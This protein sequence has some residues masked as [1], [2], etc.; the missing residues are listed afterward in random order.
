[1]PGIMGI[2]SRALVEER[3]IDQ[4]IGCLAHEPFYGFGKYINKKIGLYCGW[5]CHNGSFSD[6]MPVWN[7]TKNV[8]LIFAGEDFRDP[9]EIDILKARGHQCDSENASYLVHLYEELGLKFI[10]KLNGWF[11]GL[12]IDL[13]VGKAFLFNDRYAMHRVFVHESN[14][15][16]YFSSEAKAL[17]A[18]LPQTRKFDPKGLGEFMTCGC[19]IGNQSLYKGISILP[20]A[21]LWEFE[22]GKVKNRG[23]YFGLE[24]WTGQQKLSEDQFFYEFLETFPKV[25]KQYSSN[26]SSSVGLSLTGG[27]DSRM[28]IACLDKIPGKY[29]CYTFGSMYRDTYDVQTA[30]EVA[31]A[32]GQ[33]HNT[34]VLDDKFL[35]DFPRYLEKAVYVSDG[36]LGMWG[37]SELYL[38]SEA[39]KFGDIRLTGNYGGELLR[40]NRA[41]KSVFPRGSFIN[42]VLTT[43]L[44]EAQKT[45]KGFEKDDAVTF[46]LFRQAPSQGYGTLSIE[47]SQLLLRSPFFDNDLVKLVYQAPRRLLLNV[48]LSSKIIDKYKPSLMKIPTDRGILYCN[49]QFESSM[50]KFAR[51]FFI[52]GEYWSSHGMPNWLSV[53]SG[54]GV[55]GLLEKTFLGRDKFQH[56]R[57]WSRKKLSDYIMGELLGGIQDVE[58]IFECNRTNEMVH[59]H[60]AGR[61]NCLI[62]IDK[63]LTLILAKRTLFGSGE[64]EVKRV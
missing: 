7:E 26:S 22:Q 29:P 38:N 40:G 3:E 20:A 62:E 32:C 17:L 56:Y 39:R 63:L 59:E 34:L 21:A 57:L 15:G 41:F 51:K 23:T 6:C 1:M 55:Q 35:S 45:F 19:T 9:I 30:R 53:I 5:V 10:E 61:K 44:Q 50:R 46:A 47:R 25:V 16:L 60:M 36:Y 8:C 49:K 42:P 52:K 27:W 64:G 58:D 24:K 37:A 11:C 2:I 48:K 31:K 12:I 33:L 13:R 14:N 4:M 18:V 28:I 43:F 54:R